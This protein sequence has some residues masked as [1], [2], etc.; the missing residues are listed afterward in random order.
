M[1]ILINKTSALGDVI[2][3][4]PV[5]SYLKEKFPDATIDWIVEKH[6]HELVSSHPVINKVHIVETKKW[7]K[8]LFS[9]ET[10]SEF[11]RVK[12]DLQR[13]QYDVMF[14]LQGN[15]K[16][17]LFTFLAKAKV[18]VGFGKKT[19][20]EW[21]NLFVTDVK[22]DPPQQ[23]NVRNTYLYL[24]QSYFQDFSSPKE[25]KILLRMTAE[26]KEQVETVWENIPLPNSPTIAV[27][28]GAN[29]KNKKLTNKT[30]Q[31]I[32]EEYPGE[33]NF[34]FIWGNLE[35]KKQADCL[36]H[37]FPGKSLLV[38]KLSLSAL[39]NLFSQVDLVIA[40]DSLPLHLAGVAGTS[41]LSF[42]G[43]SLA[44]IYQPIGEGHRSFQGKCPYGV[45]FGKRC[46]KLRTCPTGACLRTLN[47]NNP[48]AYLSK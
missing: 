2:H 17:G 23:V 32:C 22:Y 4:Y 16:S 27:C 10:Y 45:S 34:L 18:K 3:C 7:R 37:H 31:R 26:E 5:I 12:S 48:F 39:Q 15:C 42:F 29:W 43:P 13:Q 41:T 38:P 11:Q 8:K 21:P 1:K 47:P 20:P 25:A 35:E 9:K 19:V 30:L 14:D 36:S 28:P 44:E 33:S 24:V 40:M 46:P 6:C